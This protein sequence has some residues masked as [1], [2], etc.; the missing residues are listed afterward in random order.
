M[1]G[2]CAWGQ[3]WP[4][5]GRGGGPSQAAL[6][7]ITGVFPRQIRDFRLTPSL[8]PPGRGQQQGGAPDL[9]IRGARPSLVAHAQEQIKCVFFVS[10]LKSIWFSSPR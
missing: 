1:K 4:A 8:S 5:R 10:A 3:H 9:L 7:V 6:V 2:A